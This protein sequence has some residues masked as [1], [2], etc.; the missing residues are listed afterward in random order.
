VAACAVAAFFVMLVAACANASGAGP[1]LGEALA[2]TSDIVNYTGMD[3]PLMGLWSS[4]G[5]RV[6]F[7]SGGPSPYLSVWNTAGS[8]LRTVSLRA[9]VVAPSLCL[10]RTTVVV[11]DYDAAD[12]PILRILSLDAAPADRE[13]Q[14]GLT[15]VSFLACAETGPLAVAADASGH[16]VVEN[17]EES[18]TVS[19]FALDGEEITS[20]A[21]SAA[22]NKVLVGTYH[23]HVYAFSSTGVSGASPIT[24]GGGSAVWGIRTSPDGTLFAEVDQQYKVGVYNSSDLTLRWRLDCGSRS[25][26]LA[27]N[28]RVPVLATAYQSTEVAYWNLETGELA[29]SF[30]SQSPGLSSLD[31]NGDGTRLLAAGMDGVG[32][33]WSAIGDPLASGSSSLLDRPW[34]AIDQPT[35]G[36]ETGVALE[37]SGRAGSRLPLL[38]IG[39]RVDDGSFVQASGNSTWSALL[40]LEGLLA[41]EH[42]VCAVA[43]NQVFASSPSCTSFRLNTTGQNQS[44]P[45]L[46]V[47]QPVEGATLSGV[48]KV[49]IRATNVSAGRLFGEMDDGEWIDLGG[50]QVC[51]WSIDSR[52]FENGSHVIRVRLEVTGAGFLE[53][54]V[55]V[56]IFNEYQDLPP[57]VTMNSPGN[58]VRLRGTVTVAGTAQDDHQLV[59]ISLRVDDGDWILLPG[60]VSWQ[61]DL[62]TSELEEGDHVIVARSW[63]GGQFSPPDW[64]IVSVHNHLLPSDLPWVSVISPQAGATLSG[65]VDVVGMANS[66]TGS[67]KVIVLID[68]LEVGSFGGGGTWNVTVD[69]TP[70]ADGTHKLRVFAEDSM[71]RSSEVERAVTFRNDGSASAAGEVRFSASW[72]LAII[73]ASCTVGVA[74]LQWRRRGRSD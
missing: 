52:N 28:P 64:R 13:Y 4:A 21:L 9:L 49:T 66:S 54:R 70:F 26:S 44:S 29:L 15:S 67:V 65:N 5:D 37:V 16:V 42:R 63:D 41:G 47:D 40:N 68:D 34:I 53:E 14:L 1:S 12:H 25:P 74:A 39:V 36:S 27:W 50:G 11:G 51:N 33:L 61:I 31:W 55:H 73:V 35:N 62:N 24:V 22:A 69:T 56:W 72:L 20:V 30:S 43:T 71:G 32:R 45:G 59:S 10:D 23:G 6:V 57:T 18:R 17:L 3:A 2:V 48:I 58:G 46:F 8:L 7:Q 38:W 60:Q 19:T